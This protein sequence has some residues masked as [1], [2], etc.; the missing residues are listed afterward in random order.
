MA[1]VL[2]LSWPQEG[3]WFF[4]QAS[5]GT[6]AY[7]IA[8]GWWLEVRL[9]MAALQRSLNDIVLRHET[10][11]TAIGAKDGKPCQIVFPPKPF[12]LAVADLRS[13]VNATAEAEKLA[14][15]DA[16]RAFD[17]AQEPLV[18]C[19]LFRVGHE[20][21]LLSVNMHHIISDAWSV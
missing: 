16:R 7:N 18:R 8:E 20:K 11:R 6:A 2:P 10:L 17:L 9:D 15:L 5:P 12:P 13:Q 21:Y 3:L 4:E 14:S 19:S 1:G